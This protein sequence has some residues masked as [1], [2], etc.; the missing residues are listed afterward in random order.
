MILVFQAT[1]MGICG[2]QGV[3]HAWCY[4]FCGFFIVFESWVFWWVENTTTTNE[5]KINKN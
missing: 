4:D 2:Q 3:G 1:S 5:L